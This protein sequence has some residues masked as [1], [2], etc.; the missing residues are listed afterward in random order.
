MLKCSPRTLPHD[1]ITTLVI[2]NSNTAQFLKLPLFRLRQSHTV[3]AS[4][5]APLPVTQLPRQTP[6]LPTTAAEAGAAVP[7]WRVNTDRV[8]VASSR[9]SS[10]LLTAWARK[11][12]ATTTLTVH[13]RTTADLQVTQARS[14]RMSSQLPA[15]HPA[16][17]HITTLTTTAEPRQQAR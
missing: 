7:N 10:R 6:T 14:G 8:A 17:C 3:L 9:T 4:R 1:L 13:H 5:A 16:R 12:L 2:V 11:T 15:M